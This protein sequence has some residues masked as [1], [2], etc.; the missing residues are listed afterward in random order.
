MKTKKVLT[1]HC[2]LLPGD[3][4]MGINPDDS[5]PYFVVSVKRLSTCTKINWLIST[6]RDGNMTF[7]SRSHYDDEL[8]TDCYVFR[9]GAYFQTT[10]T[11]LFDT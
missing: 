7:E 2:D 5:V 3:L 1:Y 6:S 8:I 10:K 9:N 4:I 11:E